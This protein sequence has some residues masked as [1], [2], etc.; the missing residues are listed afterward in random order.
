MIRTIKVSFIVIAA[1]LFQVTLFPCY[2]RDPFQPNLMIIFVVYL[3]LRS[4]SLFGGLAAFSIGLMQ[5]CFSGLYLGLNGFSYLCIYLL[6][7]K[8]SDRLYTNSRYLIILVVF[9]ATIVSGMLNLLLLL[10][11]SA[12]NDIYTTLLPALIPQALVNALIASLIFSFPVFGVVEEG[13]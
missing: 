5:D 2:L 4:T 3:V 13:R 7:D 10:I 9:L 8:I 11:F 1:L 12:A 6:L